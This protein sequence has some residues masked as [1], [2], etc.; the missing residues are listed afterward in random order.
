MDKLAEF[1]FRIEYRPGTANPADALSRRADLRDVDEITRSKRSGL[2]AFLQRFRREKAAFPGTDVMDHTVTPRTYAPSDSLCTGEGSQPSSVLRACRVAAANLRRSRNQHDLDIRM[3]LT[4]QSDRGNPA[5]ACAWEQPV[6]VAANPRETL[7]SIA[8]TSPENEDL[9]VAILKAQQED[10]FA[11]RVRSYLS[12]PSRVGT[13]SYW[14]KWSSDLDGLL[15]YKGRVFVPPIHRP[16]ILLLFHDDP[17]AGH[18]GI[19]R[20]FARI[21]QS[22]YWTGLRKDVKTHVLQCPICQKTK[23][24]QHRPYGYLASLPTPT[25]PWVEISMDFIMDLPTAAGKQRGYDTILVIMDRFTKYAHYIPTTKR[26]TSDTLATIF[27]DHIFSKY[28][29]PEGIVSDRGTLFTSAF[30]RSFCAIL[31]CKRR[32]STAFHPQTDGQTERQNQNLEHYLRAFCAKNQLDWPQHL[33]LAEFTYNTAKHSAHGDT[34]A[35]LLRGFQ[36][37]TPF[38]TPYARDKL[39]ASAE[40]RVDLLRQQHGI[41]ANALRKASESYHT[42]YDTKRRSK[43]FDI[44][45][46]VLISTKNLKLKR[47]SRKLAEKFVGPYQIIAKVG[48]TNN[49]YRLRLPSSMRIHNVFNI[50]SLEPFVRGDQEPTE[51]TDHP[52]ADEETYDV[53]RI[54]GHK[55]NGRRRLYLVKWKDCDESENTYQK[56]SDFIDRACIDDYEKQLRG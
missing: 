31:A 42:W 33:S 26:V 24:R 52:F 54:M 4:R 23:P 18:Q 6:K 8:A 19:R 22:Y 3:V 41:A 49:A 2:P 13:R 39:S 11:T 28:G 27:L 20:T 21:S 45:D 15:R 9:K 56:K 46:W 34:P 7:Q 44:D 10:A 16:E 17:T 40:S 32:L 38:D 50:A 55:F 5:S 12:S 36:P 1:N 51:P 29:M 53:E 47:P 30:W 35:N 37:R 14:S 25:R 48:T 43:S